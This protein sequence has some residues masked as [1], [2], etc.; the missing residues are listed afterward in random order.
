VGTA[1]CDPKKLE[2]VKRMLS[3]VV[4]NSRVEEWLSGQVPHP[5]EFPNHRSFVQN[6]ETVWD[7]NSRGEAGERNGEDVRAA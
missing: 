3:Q 7:L 5:A 2:R 1:D 6:S 4:S